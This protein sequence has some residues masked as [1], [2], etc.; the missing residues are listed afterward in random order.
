ME[1]EMIVPPMPE[2]RIDVFTL[3]KLDWELDDRF[4]NG[5]FDDQNTEQL[6]D[7][8]IAEIDRAFPIS[9]EWNGWVFRISG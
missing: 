3:C 1:I 5:E 6:T 8:E 2:E 9:Y 4:E 7:V